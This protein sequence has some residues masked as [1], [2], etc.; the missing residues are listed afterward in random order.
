MRMF[1]S[2][3]MWG[4]L[5]RLVV[6]A[7]D[8]AVARLQSFTSF[9]EVDTGKLAGGEILLHRG[10]LMD[11]RRGI[12]GESCFVVAATPEATADRLQNIDLSQKKDSSVSFHQAIHNPIQD[13][14]LATLDLGADRFAVRRFVSKTLA[15][16]APQDEFYLSRDEA[17]R[18]VKL[19]KSGKPAEQSAAKARR[20]W[21]EILKLRA[22]EF[23]QTGLARLSPYDMAKGT[24]N[25]AADIKSLLAELPRIA[26]EF[27]GLMSDTGLDGEQAFKK[28]A[29][30]NQYCELINWD[31]QATLQLGAVFRRAFP[32]GHIQL[33]DCGYFSTGI[34]Y[35]SLIFYELW[36]VQIGGKPA[37][38]A[39]RAD[40]LSTPSLEVTRGIERL[41][42]GKIMMLEIKKFIQDF[43]KDLARK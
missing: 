3:V 2:S 30:S 17:Q 21:I 13:A 24:I 36:P 43:R 26:G 8:P 22:A 23:Q 12:C 37:T 27:K 14:D 19:L 16:T 33:L 6:A 5:A 42:F 25:P 9:S 29:V 15:L 11:F 40:L 35:V 10:S 31:I 18:M 34:Y 4:A 41:A 38:L 32:D 20:C 39:W 28:Q 7:G 1:I